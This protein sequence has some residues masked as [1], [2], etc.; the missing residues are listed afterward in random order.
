V[1]LQHVQRLD[2][3]GTELV[4]FL[5]DLTHPAGL[6][7]VQTGSEGGHLLDVLLSLRLPLEE[8]VPQRCPSVLKVLQPKPLHLL[9]PP[10]PLPP[11]LGLQTAADLLL[12]GQVPA[13]VLQLGPQGLQQGALAGLQTVLVTQ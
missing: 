10:L 5:H 12:P 11:G 13:G 4:E 3:P 6:A 9:L 8:L 7:A 1:G 2:Q